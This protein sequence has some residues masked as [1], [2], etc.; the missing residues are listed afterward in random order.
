M[1][2]VENALPLLEGLDKFVDIITRSSFCALR[3]EKQEHYELTQDI[4]NILIG[5]VSFSVTLITDIRN[6]LSILSSFKTDVQKFI[7]KPINSVLQIL[8]PV[9][10][11]M[12]SL[13]FL[14]TIA[15]FKIGIPVGVKI[16]WWGPIPYPKLEFRKMG[17][18]ELGE[19]VKKV[20]DF[21]KSIP[22]IGE[23]VSVVESLIDEALSLIFKAIGVDLPDFG[24]DVPFIEQ[25]KRKVEE[26]FALSDKFVDYLNNIMDLD[27]KFTGL[28]EPIIEPLLDAIPSVDDFGIDCTNA[29]DPLKCVFKTFDIDVNFK[30]P[31][32]IL[33]IPDISVGNLEM[34][35]IQRAL[36]LLEDLVLKVE[37]FQSQVTNLFKGFECEK[38][39]TV[40][41]EI[42]SFIE[43]HFDTPIPLSVC[44]ITFEVCTG[45]RLP[46]A[47]LQ[48]LL[49]E[50]NITIPLSSIDGNNSIVPRVLQQNTSTS[51]TPSSLPISI[52]SSLPSLSSE[53]SKSSEPSLLPSELPPD[54]ICRHKWPNDVYWDWGLSFS[55]PLT[56]AIPLPLFESKIF[57]GGEIWSPD[58]FPFSFGVTGKTNFLQSIGVSFGCSKGEMQLKFTTPPLIST[59]LKLRD[60]N[61]A[62]TL[63]NNFFAPTK[64]AQDSL[65]YLKGET[66]NLDKFK[67]ETAKVAVLNKILCHLDYLYVN[68]QAGD[69][70]SKPFRPQHKEWFDKYTDE[71]GI[72]P[73]LTNQMIVED[74][75]NFNLRTWKDIEEK[76]AKDVKKSKDRVKK[77]K[78]L[79]IPDS[80]Y[81]S[82]F[83]YDKFG[84]QKSCGHAKPKW[85]AT[86]AKE[87]G[88]NTGQKMLES[89]TINF[90]SFNSG[91]EPYAINSNLRSIDLSAKDGEAANFDIATTIISIITNAGVRIGGI[92]TQKY[93][94]TMEDLKKEEVNCKNSNSPN[95]CNQTKIDELSNKTEELKIGFL[96]LIPNMKPYVIFQNMQKYVARKKREKLTYTACTPKDSMFDLITKEECYIIPTSVSS[97]VSKFSNFH[98]NTIIR[99]LL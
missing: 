58:K 32:N 2:K 23:L 72:A 63:K 39:E 90:F 84:R 97:E 62:L 68:N 19:I 94:K 55:I 47:P 36:T 69:N 83:P 21:I 92:G 45:I 41:I 66:P 28:L 86:S 99:T 44:P 29:D 65:L 74:L 54:Y 34:P 70:Q 67:D 60:Q 85:Y 51:S 43:S 24:L 64:F 49:E 8:E 22:L 5:K 11:V 78:I 6:P 4:I 31:E 25:F 38:Y 20:I 52:P 40:P 26:V 18:E 76:L 77:R 79:R 71:K 89:L 81:Y 95:L 1:L 87:R 35:P 33:D 13:E 46:S 27:G 53:P 9:F 14:K 80:E 57:Q 73:I 16:K 3:E 15:S 93:L 50:F 48:T 59:N 75:K 56:E 12:S 30:A 82:N 17:L 91:F 98:L 42:L 96:K 61:F 7:I 37:N 88:K 10:S